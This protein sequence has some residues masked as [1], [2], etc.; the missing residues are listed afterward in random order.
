MIDETCLLVSIPGGLLLDELGI[1]KIIDVHG[2]AHLIESGG[3]HLS[4]SF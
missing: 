2:A 3:C 4:G 1:I